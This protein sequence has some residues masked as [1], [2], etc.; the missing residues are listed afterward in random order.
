MPDAV[1]GHFC[2]FRLLP[3][4][5]SLPCE[6]RRER[7]ARWFTAHRQTADE[8]RLYLT[9]GLESEGDVLL[10]TSVR[11]SSPERPAAYFRE[12][13][14][15][16]NAH[17][18]VIEPRHALW[19]MTRPSE[20]SRAAKSAQEIDPFSPERAP[21]LIMYP[22]TKTAEWYLLGRD[23]RQGMMNEHIRI[24]KQY[25]EITQ[26]LLYS[27][28]LQDQEFVVVYETHDLQLFSKLVYEMRDTEAR[29]YTKAD[30][31]LHTGVLVEPD[32]W[33]ELVA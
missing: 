7:A 26:L 29:R 20:Y 4:F 5:W 25:E 23:T 13:A 33:A 17:R 3:A 1:L 12:R 6:E 19:G 31:P 27:F 14:A 24:G 30:T 22:F 32:R 28:G 16:E 15:A 21:Y 9:Q 8:A 10:W 18:D 11:V 2:T